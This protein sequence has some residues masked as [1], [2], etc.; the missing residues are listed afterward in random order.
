MIIATYLGW[1]TY[2]IFNLSFLVPN[3]SSGSETTD[4]TYNKIQGYPAFY[5]LFYFF[6]CKQES[7]QESEYDFC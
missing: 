4:E 1:S 2:F 6:L 5:F 3:H 7:L